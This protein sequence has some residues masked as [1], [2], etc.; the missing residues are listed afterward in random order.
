NG[1]SF[2]K[3][4]IVSENIANDLKTQYPTMPSY[5]DE[6]G[7]KIPAGWLIE[8]MGWKGVRRGDAGVYEKQALVLVNFGSASPKEVLMLANDIINSVKE[9]F[10]ILISPEINII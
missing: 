2:F 3:N 5:P 1:G 4:P 7:V 8:Q 9:K 6:K 10:G